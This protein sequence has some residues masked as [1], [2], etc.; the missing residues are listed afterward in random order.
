MASDLDQAAT[1]IALAITIRCRRVAQFCSQVAGVVFAQVLIAAQFPDVLQLTRLVT[2]LRQKR[3]LAFRRVDL[4][5]GH[6]CVE[7][8]YKN[9]RLAAGVGHDALQLLFSDGHTNS[10]HKK[11]ALRRQWDG[12]TA[13]RCSP[14]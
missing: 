1:A 14:P 5:M 7:G 3:G 8:G 13:S 6:G 2:D 4:S 11:A 9:A 10:R 12:V